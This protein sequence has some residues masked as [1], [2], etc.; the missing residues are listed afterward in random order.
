MVLQ[1]PAPPKR[2]TW[3]SPGAPDLARLPTHPVSPTAAVPPAWNVNGGRRRRPPFPSYLLP[4]MQP[5]APQPPHQPR[6]QSQSQSH[7]HTHMLL[8]VPLQL[9]FR[10]FSPTRPPHFLRTCLSLSFS[11]ALSCSGALGV[12]VWTVCCCCFLICYLCTGRATLQP[13]LLILS[14]RSWAPPCAAVL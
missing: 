12:A 14:L 13:A 7:T 8:P 9:L 11:F 1:P 6:I 3:P 2:G 4:H 10:P 5:E